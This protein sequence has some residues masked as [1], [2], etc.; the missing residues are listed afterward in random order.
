MPRHD[1]L[2]CHSLKNVIDEMVR[3]GLLDKFVKKEKKSCNV[4]RKDEK[5][6][7][8]KPEVDARKKQDKPQILVIYGGSLEGGESSWQKKHWATVPFVISI[9]EGQI[10]KRQRREPLYFTDEDLPRGEVHSDSLVIVMDI[11]GV[12][13]EHI[14]VDTRSSVNILYKD[15]F[16][17]LG[18]DKARLKPTRVPLLCF[19]GDQIKA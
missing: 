19:T 17:K 16:E 8:R 7:D 9:Q 13:V 14:L 1:T 12:D 18:V 2:E 6:E 15:V 4:F 5:K 3:N 10:E 11:E